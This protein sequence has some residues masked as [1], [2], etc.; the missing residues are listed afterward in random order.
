MNS[1]LTDI[2]NISVTN[3]VHH[4]PH[5]ELDH[6]ILNVEFDSMGLNLHSLDDSHD[7]LPFSERRK[8]EEE[9]FNLREDK[10]GSENET[11][12]EKKEEAAKGHHE[13]GEHGHEETGANEKAVH[14]SSGNHD[15][16]PQDICLFLFIMMLIGHIMKQFSAWTGIPY[17]SLI[18][19]I[20][21]V[22][23]V[24]EA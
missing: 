24:L 19:V 20:G 16:L 5:L 2:S 22:F 11:E 13:S 18:T 9:N 6:H 3:N 7:K 15:T 12:E 4:G 23:G 8:L 17:T 1:S 21:L 10:V 14:H